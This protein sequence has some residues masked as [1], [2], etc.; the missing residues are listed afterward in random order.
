MLSHS[1]LEL[2][3]LLTEILITKLKHVSYVQRIACFLFDL[4][5]CATPTGSMG[6]VVSQRVAA[7]LD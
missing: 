3:D 1:N 4:G 5:F 6:F 7:P 2:K